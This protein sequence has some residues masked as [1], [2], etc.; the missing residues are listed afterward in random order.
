MGYMNYS[1]REYIPKP[2]RFYKCHKMGHTTQQCKGKLRFAICRCGGQH[3]Y[4]N[5]KKKRMLRLGA[6][7]VEENIVLRFDD[8]KYLEKPEKFR[9]LGF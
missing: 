2:L 5:R 9:R 7:I 1:V 6:V 3:E 8:A 4:G